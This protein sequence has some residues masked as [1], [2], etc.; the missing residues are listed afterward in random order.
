MPEQILRMTGVTKRFRGVMALKDVHLELQRGEVHAICGENGAGKSTLMEILSGVHP[1]GSFAGDVVFEGREMR[2]RSLADS[3]AEGIVIIHQ[4]LAVVPQLTVAENIFLGH[5]VSRFGLVDEAATHAR[6]AE[7]LASVGLDENPATRMGELGIGKQQ[8]V[9]IAKALAKN[10]KLLILDEPTAA[11]GREDSDRL[12]ALVDRFRSHGITCVLIS[13]K[14]REVL[15]VAD[16]ITV[17]RDGAVVE[18][19]RADD[20]ETDEGRIIRAMVGRPLDDLFPPREPDIGDEMFGIR[21]WTVVHP[22]DPGRVIIDDV[23][24]HVRAGEIVG[25]AGLMGAGRTELAM[26]IFGRSYGGETTGEAFKRGERIELRTIR[27]AIGHGIAYVP[28][29]RRDDGLNLLASVQSNISAAALGR[30][31]TRGLVDEVRERKVAEAYRY[32]MNIKTSSVAAITATLSGGNQQKTVLSR[33][34]F[35]NP[36]VLILDE[37]T[38]GID[39]GAK[40]EIYGLINE[41]AAQ[42]KAIIVISSELPEVIGLSDRVYTLAH[43]RITAEFVRDD[44]TQE[45]L[46]RHMAAEK[47]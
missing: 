17:L 8:M 3:E 1:H 47:S 26:S 15:G 24:M 5:E 12:L 33:W 43:G 37:P 36:D 6:A 2:F 16:R 7:L 45:L 38:R 13:H 39:V 40:Y 18:T 32:K 14:L 41:L 22:H 27:E 42:G 46:M 31:A 11:L 28:E 10:V 30:L 35:T 23:S 19:M 29:D 25:I 4:E 44:L 34:M 20:P 9:E 21:N